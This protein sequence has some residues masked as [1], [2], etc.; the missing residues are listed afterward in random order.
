MGRTTK[1]EHVKDRRDW[2][3]LTPPLA[4]WIREAVSSMGYTR[5]TPVQADTIPLFLKNRDVVVEVSYILIVISKITET[6]HL[7]FATSRLSLAAGK[8]SRSYY[9]LFKRSWPRMSPR[10]DIMSPPSSFHPQES[11]QHRFFRFSFLSFRFTLPR[12]KYC[13]F[14]LK[15]KSDRSLRLLLSYRN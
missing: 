2:N 9:L 14:F 10:S 1:S 8:H 3:T 11:L 5:M 13:H 7:S 4:E 12:L 6:N 15:T